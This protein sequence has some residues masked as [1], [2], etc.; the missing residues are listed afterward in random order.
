MSA[1]DPKRTLATDH[2]NEF[3]W[4][5]TM[6]ANTGR[7]CDYQVEFLDQR[8]AF[9]VINAFNPLGMIAEEYRLPSGIWM[10]AHDWM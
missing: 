10:Y 7:W 4:T 9:F 2:L 5:P 8:T 3:A 6:R 1:Y